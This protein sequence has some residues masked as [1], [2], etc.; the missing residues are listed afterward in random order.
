[1]FWYPETYNLMFYSKHVV[2]TAVEM[3][4]NIHLLCHSFILYTGSYIFQQ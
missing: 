4:N 2:N 1:M 3:T